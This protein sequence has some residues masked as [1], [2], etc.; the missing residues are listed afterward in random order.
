MNLGTENSDQKSQRTEYTDDLIEERILHYLKTHNGDDSHILEEFPK[1]AAFHYFSVTRANILRWYPFTNRDRVLEVGAG[2]GALT[3]YLAETCGHVVALEPSAV[4]SEIVRIRCNDYQNTEVLDVGLQE[5]TVPGKFDYVILVGVLEYAFALAQGDNP[6]VSLLKSA[7][8]R[9]APGGKLLLAIENK[10]GLKYWCGASEDHTGIPFDSIND[11]SISG[12]HHYEEIQQ[13]NGVRTFGRVEL[14]KLLTHA[15]FEHYQFFYPFPDYKYPSA[16]LSDRTE[17]AAE[18]VAQT[19]FHYT[20]EAALVA[21]ERSVWPE[22]IE[23]GCLGFFTNSFFVEAAREDVGLCRIH[24]AVMKRDYKR[25]FSLTTTLDGLS[26]RRK[27]ACREASSHLRS[28]EENTRFLQ[29][30]GVACVNQ[31]QAENGESIAENIHASRA[32][33]VLADALNAGN[34]ELAT[35][36]LKQL[37]SNLL[38]SSDSYTQNG[39]LVL[40]TGF[41]DLNL[42]NAFWVDG[43]LMFFDQEWREAN[44]PLN[45]IAYR[46][47]VYSCG[48]LKN[49]EMMSFAYRFFGISEEDVVLYKKKETAFLK[50]LMD[51]TACSFFDGQMYQERLTME[52]KINRM[53]ASKEAHIEQLLQSERE[54]EQTIR[55]KEGHIE[56]LLESDRELDRI[57]NSRSWKILSVWWGFRDSLLPQNSRRRLL[58][59]LGF[60]FARHPVRFMQKL[61][62]GHIKTF[63]EG[64][65]SGSIASTSERLDNYLGRDGVK[66][67]K[68]K[69]L[70]N[71]KYE[72]AKDYPPI[73]VP[74]SYTPLVSI[75]IPVFN[76]FAYTYNCVQSIVNHT[77]K[78]PYEVIIADDCSDDLT[79]SL[80]EIIEGVRIVRNETNLRFLKNCNRAADFAKGK[81]ILFLNN[82]TQVQKDWLSSLVELIESADDIGMVGSKLIYPDGRLQEAGGIVW[83]D[84]SVWNYGHGQ[85][86]GMPEYNYVK[87]TDYISGASI[88]IRAKLWRE[89]GGF[90]ERFAPAYYE[91]TDLA[92]SVRQRGCRVLY[93]PLSVVV[94]FE[95]VSN[96]TDTSAGLKAYQVENQKKFREKW[97][98]VLQREHD[99]NGCNVF[100]ARDRSQKKKHILVVDHYVPHFDKDA[101]G[102]CTFMYLKLFVKMGF[103]V[104]F[105]GD[106]FFRHEPYTTVLNQLGI[107]VLYGDSY[108]LGRKC[109][110][111]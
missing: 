16:I 36:V 92:F 58:L 22:I 108:F 37:R 83:K 50:S 46:S 82:D 98:E 12:K 10:Y 100:K 55:N 97:Q 44:V 73:R 15:G 40:E 53:L 38:R 104:T 42:Q 76:E 27:A 19:K 102:R 106:N 84:A 60:K 94:H 2:L 32:D 96:G 28:L 61:D 45:Y 79:K 64:L 1:T 69:L 88:M 7:G 43:S 31:V 90:D 6:W 101:G 8:E 24:T 20:D 17:N 11:Y 52:G 59:K 99:P 63:R 77:G 107:E 54:L 74:S 65:R 85:D 78:V 67:E 25:E 93:Q 26:V 110:A 103:Q 48:H 3:T 91:D 39:K 33:R 62:M 70:P 56:L 57:H 86:P 75:I 89:I 34:T 72:K 35:M 41:L 80:G 51:D 71:K 66:A 13:L 23:N 21:D 81:Y 109:L 87:E 29:E 47:I 95:G 111:V 30:R 18:I 4:R 14:E 5:Y 9:L 49:I 105:I 68:P